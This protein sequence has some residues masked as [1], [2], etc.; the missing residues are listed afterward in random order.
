MRLLKKQQA[1]LNE[2]NGFKLIEGSKCYAVR[3]QKDENGN[4]VFSQKMYHKRRVNA[5]LYQFKHDVAEYYDFSYSLSNV[6][7]GD[8][9]MFFKDAKPFL[10]VKVI[11]EV[12]NYIEVETI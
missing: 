6:H 4:I 1:L 3:C 7:A 9:I 12:I 2:Q 8:Y 5:Y 10:K 11:K